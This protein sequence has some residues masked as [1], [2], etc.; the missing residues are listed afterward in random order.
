MGTAGARAQ[1]CQGSEAIGLKG[2]RTQRQEDS[3]HE[4]RDTRHEG[5]RA[6]GLGA[7]ALGDDQA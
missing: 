7:R 6:R 1:R 2:A 4:T 3:R 5:S